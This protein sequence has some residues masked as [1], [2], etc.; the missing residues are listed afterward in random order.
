MVSA[1]GLAPADDDERPIGDAQIADDRFGAYPADKGFASVAWG[2]RWAADDG[3]LVAAA[4][5]RAA[6]RAWPAAAGR[7]AAGRRQAVEQ[8]IAQLKGR[9]A[10]E[11]HRAETLGG[12]LARPAAKAAAY[13][14]GQALNR[15]RGRPLRHLADLLV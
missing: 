7:W 3:A 14:G 12:L 13:T 15:R 4:P 5:T 8:A 6:R 11:R 2:R 1:I 9:F 10:S